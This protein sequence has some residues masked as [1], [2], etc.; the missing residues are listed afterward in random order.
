MI[1]SLS[2]AAALALMAA[3]NPAA[4][5]VTYNFTQQGPATAPN[6]TFAGAYQPLNVTGSLTVSDSAYAAGWS[7]SAQSTPRDPVAAPSVLEALSVQ[8]AGLSSAAFN[9][10]TFAQGASSKGIFTVSLSGGVNGLFGSLTTLFQS[11][12]VYLT[13]TGNSFT[14]RIASDARNDC[15]SAG[16]VFGG[17]ITT[18]TVTTVPEPASMALFGAGLLGLVAVRRRGALAA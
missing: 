16:C 1:R 8:V 17:T 15:G 2:V 9:L 5:S 13:F 4:A 14:G 10:P 18:S 7:A 11:D 6:A 12:D 3:A